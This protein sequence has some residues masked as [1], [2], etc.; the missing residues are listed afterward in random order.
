VA[1]LYGIAESSA[2]PDRRAAIAVR[3]HVGQLTGRHPSAVRTDA[4]VTM[5]WT[6]D[7]PHVIHRFAVEHGH[8][9]VTVRSLPPH[10]FPN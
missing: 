7:A 6:S 9:E 10:G 5:A 8:H 4:A 3:D 2:G 1:D